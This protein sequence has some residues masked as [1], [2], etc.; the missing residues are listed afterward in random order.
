ML[1]QVHTGPAKSTNARHLQV[2]L[3]IRPIES[4][5]A[6]ALVAGFEQLS[7]TSRYLRFHGGMR[8]MPESLVR[9]L[10]QV[11][12]V[13]HVAL[14]AF[15][16]TVAGVG[17]G[18]AVGRFVRSKAAPNTAEL[19]VTVIDAFQGRGVARQL[20][21][22]LGDAARARGIET[23][24]MSVL[25]GNARARR[26]LRSLGAVGQ[27]SSGDVSTFHVPVT[28]LATAA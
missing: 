23:F 16:E 22:A 20:L 3:H 11:D 4:T 12:G 18:V 27:G 21:A 13:D 2:R 24:T 17:Q 6:G 25:S 7:E 28:S 26:L 9:Y 19:A 10:T 15:E 14:V 8:R 5:D 1:S